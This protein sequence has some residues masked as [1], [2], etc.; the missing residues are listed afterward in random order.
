MWE[1]LND[2]GTFAVSSEVLMI[3]VNIGKSSL[4]QSFKSHVG[5]GS[6]SHDLLGDNCIILLTSSYEVGLNSSRRFSTE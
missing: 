5:M 1:L 2:F 6:S 3:F 4:R